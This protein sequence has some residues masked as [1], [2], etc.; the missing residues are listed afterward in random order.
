MRKK[1]LNIMRAV[2]ADLA[3]YGDNYLG[4]GWTK[5]QEDA[6]LRY[7][8]MLDLI[9]PGTVDR[10]RLLDFGCGASHLYEYI[11]RNAIG[12][13]EYCGLDISEKFIDISR[14]KYPELTYFCLDILEDS[15]WIEVPYCD[16]AVMNGLFTAKIDL[17]FEEMF[18]YMKR[19]VSMVFAK[20][21]VGIAFNVMSK[22]VEWERDDLFHVPFDV[23]AEFLT[24]NISRHFVVRHD[25]G[26]YEYAVYVY[27][28]STKSAKVNNE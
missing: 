23:L 14:S 9:W 17:S 16:Y 13:I 3:R 4:V 22:Q 24:N 7:K 8:I 21:R 20:A 10:V 5:R 12:N 2:E 18:D 15:S 19:I 1:Y 26:L 27:R 11:L 25:Y 28:E 6:D